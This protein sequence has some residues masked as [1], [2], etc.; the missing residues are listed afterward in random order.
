MFQ[1]SNDEY[2]DIYQNEYSDR[3]RLHVVRPA[4]TDL[5]AAFARRSLDLEYLSISFMVDAW[6]FFSACHT[7][8]TWMNLT[9]LVLVS[10]ELTATNDEGVIHKLL[11]GAAMTALRMPNLHSMTLW[12]VRED[13]SCAFKYTKTE[14]TGTVMWQGTWDMYLPDF[15]FRAWEAVSV[16]PPRASNFLTRGQFIRD[17]SFSCHGEA[18]FWLDLPFGVIDPISLWQIG[19]EAT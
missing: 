3:E 2:T 18:I 8:W 14:S 1:D 10:A 16:Q 19:E 6:D 15:V 11:H 4:Y 13:G 9:T 17:R 12:N 5:A 7:Q